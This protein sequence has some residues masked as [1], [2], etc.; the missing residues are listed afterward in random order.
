[1]LTIHY[2][3]L[4]DWREATDILRC[5]PMFYGKPRYDCV[6]IHAAEGPDLI[7]RL[8]FMFTCTVG[9]SQEPVAMVQFYD[10][11]QG[12]KSPKDVDLG[13]YRVRERKQNKLAWISLHSIRRGVVLVPDFGVP[14]DFLVHD[15]IDSDIFLRMKAQQTQ[16]GW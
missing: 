13:F 11:P 5:S 1:M 15:L 6:L 14:G 4:A 7:A 12:P 16:F 3:S 9:D 8:L 10:R 2:E